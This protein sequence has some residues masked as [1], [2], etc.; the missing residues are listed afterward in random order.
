MADFISNNFISRIRRK[1]YIT[2]AVIALFIILFSVF[3]YFYNKNNPVDYTMYNSSSLSYA[4]AQVIEV[5]EDN[6]T[7]DAVSKDRYYGVQ[8][9]NIKILQGK[10]EGQ[11]MVIDNYL[12]TTHNVRLA[13]G[14]YFVACIDRAS[15]A[16]N[17]TMIVSAY[18]YYR[19]PYLYIFAGIL[20][21]VIVIIGHGK[22]VRAIIGLAFS[23]Y[24][25]IGFMLPLIFKGY[26]PIVVCII[27][28]ILTTAVTLFLLNGNSEKTWVATI[29]SGAGVIISGVIFM[30]LAAFIHVSG[31]N[32]DQAE[33][34][35]LISKSTGLEI[36]E[37]LFA[38]ILISSVGA[39]MDV[40][41]SMSSAL[42]EMTRHVKISQKQL[43]ISGINIGKDMIGTMCNTLIM[44]FTGSAITT[45][46]TFY[47]YGITYDQLINSDYIAEEI[48]RGLCGTLG[49]VLTV[50]I[51][52]ALA[53]VIWGR[54]K[55]DE[56]NEL[57]ESNESKETNE[58]NES[59]EFKESNEL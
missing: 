33:S 20:M 16:E 47:A 26:S 17:A 56:R 5:V 18:N 38:G 48:A 29:S 19:A 37:V 9:L 49:I 54:H 12:S 44:A 41:M 32:T 2:D 3:V 58:C 10:F 50:P 15:E 8:S 34:L 14:E 13:T 57:K 28:V 21:A 35:I 31:Y 59:K 45:L 43:F 39:V 6:T 55:S 7:Q 40:G 30:I 4:K 24:A 53:A 23:L 46:L 52:T 42:Y 25:V 51:C 36:D 11:Q 27:V 1:V 22:G